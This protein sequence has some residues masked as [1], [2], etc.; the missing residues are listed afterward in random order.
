MVTMVRLF[1]SPRNVSLPRFVFQLSRRQTTRIIK[2]ALESL[3][4][5]HFMIKSRPREDKRSERECYIL[6]EQ[7]SQRKKEKKKR[8]KMNFNVPLNEGH[9]IN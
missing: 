4:T 3:I 7:I 1:V 2:S 6:V 5:K 8:R 9:S